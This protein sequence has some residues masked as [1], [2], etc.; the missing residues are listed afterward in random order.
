MEQNVPQQSDL[1][2]GTSELAAVLETMP[3]GVA[4]FNGDDMLIAANKL[5]VCLAP[6]LAGIVQPGVHWHQLVAEMASRG[7]GD[8]FSQLNSHLGLGTPGPCATRLTRYD[9]PWKEIE[10]KPTQTDGFTLIVSDYDPAKD[11]DDLS[12]QADDL[13]HEVLDASAALL[14]MS[15][16]GS[17]EILYR[18]PDWAQLYGKARSDKELFV[19][20]TARADFLAELLPTGS[21]ENFEVILRR[22]DGTTFPGRVSARIVEYRG[23]EVIVSSSQDMTRL[24]AQRDEILHS[25]Q[26]LMDAIEALDQGFALFGADNSLLVANEQYLRINAP[27]IDILKM[28]QPNAVIVEHAKKAGHPPLLAGWFGQADA[29]SYEV[30]HDNGLS[31]A[32]TRSPTPRSELVVTVRDIT[33]QKH[34]ERELTRRREASL[35][36]EKMMALGEL[37]AGVAHELNNPLSVIVGQT[38]MMCEENHEPETKRRI[39][40]ISIAAERCSK[41]VKTFLAMAR[42]RPSSISA[43]DINQILRTAVEVASIGHIAEDTEIRLDLA[44]SLPPVMADEDQIAQVFL[45][46]ILN[47]DQALK[48]GADEHG[49]ISISTFHDD[50]TREVVV[51]FADNGPGVPPALRAR[52]FEPFFTT[53]RVGEGTGVGLAL[54]HRVIGSHQGQMD[55]GDTPGGGALFTIRLPAAVEN[56]ADQLPAK[57][58]YSISNLTILVVE[59]EPEVAETIIDL[60]RL[61]GARVVHAASAEAGLAHIDAGAVFDVILSDLRM[62]GLSGV[63]FWDEVCARSCDMAHRIGFITGDAMSKEAEAVRTNSDLPFLEKPVAHEDLRMLIQTLVERKAGDLQ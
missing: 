10:L 59:D 11:V 13:L 44:E 28:G 60:L 38:L 19:D 37:L 15:E 41:I 61:D 27:I 49:R 48:E 17:G 53:K 40:K 52:I 45:N 62:P 6:G 2:P 4:V 55:I 3:V 51:L 46:L 22:G 23:T 18:S 21:I 43:S 26:R 47:A 57:S 30:A 63:G 42:Q 31:F 32:V 58:A 29:S 20:P 24:Y 34:A 7:H 54:S 5:F 36:N 33:G 12:A 14:M 1:R 35:Q 50:E 8:A 39:D 56:D 9:A 16:V 25:N